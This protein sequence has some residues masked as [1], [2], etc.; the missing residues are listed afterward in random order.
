MYETLSFLP[1]PGFT[2]DYLVTPGEQPNRHLAGP[3]VPLISFPLAPW[4][5]WVVNIFVSV[6]DKL[7]LSNCMCSGCLVSMSCACDFLV[8]VLNKQPAVQLM[9]WTV[10]H[11]RPGKHRDTVAFAATASLGSFLRVDRPGGGAVAFSL[12]CRDTQ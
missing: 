10:S 6:T 3:W 7:L 1:H 8:V 2:S 4:T 11:C 9:Q 12:L 5:T